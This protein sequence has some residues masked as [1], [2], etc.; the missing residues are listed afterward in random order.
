MVGL[1]SV[2][3]LATCSLQFPQ[4]SKAVS[5]ELPVA[6]ADVAITSIAS[7]TLRPTCLASDEATSRG[8]RTM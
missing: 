2:V 1:F 5:A 3:Q 6:K 7:S 8:S 4:I